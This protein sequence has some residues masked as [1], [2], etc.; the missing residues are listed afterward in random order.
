[1]LS[2][3]SSNIDEMVSAAFA[4]KGP[5][6]SKEEAHWRVLSVVSF[7]VVGEAFVGMEPYGKLFW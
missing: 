7:A 4:E 6:P 1:M 2:W 5:L 3:R